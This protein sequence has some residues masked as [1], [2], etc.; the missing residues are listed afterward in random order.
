MKFCENKILTITVYDIRILTML[1][2]AGWEPQSSA[3]RDQ[4]TSLRS[5]LRKRESGLTT[6]RRELS[7]S[8]V[9]IFKVC[10]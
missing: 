6:A 1:P 8:Q 3:T 4:R 2:H 9:S 7:Q 10:H 5:Q